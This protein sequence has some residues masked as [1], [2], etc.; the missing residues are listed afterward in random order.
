MENDLV[1]KEFPAV[2]RTGFSNST[3]ALNDQVSH[4]RVLSGN[5]S[6]N[7]HTIDTVYAKVTMGG[8]A[9]Q[10]SSLVAMLA[11]QLEGLKGLCWA[12][13]SSECEEADRLDIEQWENIGA[14][15][16]TRLR[17]VFEQATVLSGQPDEPSMLNIEQSGQVLVIRAPQLRAGAG[18]LPV[19][20]A[21]MPAGFTRD[22]V[23]IWWPWVMGG[24]LPVA[25]ESTD[26]SAVLQEI[27]ILSPA[28]LQ[29]A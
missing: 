27:T 15:P 18:L 14:S 4:L 20:G 16:P 29:V 23:L 13:I 10:S 7:F 11:A 28:D 8:L 26:L 2:R 5:L 3:L 1:T 25:L 19:W 21:L 22:E 12:S 17:E 6:S 9:R 24:N